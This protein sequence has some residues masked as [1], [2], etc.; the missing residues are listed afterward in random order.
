MAAW[1]LAESEAR[2]A[3]DALVPL[4][5]HDSDR[6]VRKT[7]VWALGELE[8]EKAVPV[9]AEVLADSDP[10]VRETAAWAL[11]Q[12]E[13]RP[14]PAALVKAITDPDPQVRLAAAWSLSQIGDAA[15]VPALVRAFRAE[16]DEKVRRAEIRALGEA[17][18]MP[19]EVVKEM[20]DSKDARTREMGVRSLAGHR[21]PWPWPWPRPRP[22]PAP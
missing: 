9:L 4:M 11:G 14:A 1:A 7:A 18:E 16:K 15:A 10:E 20:L 5:R 17:G 8:V 13:P 21:A 19:D 12:I 22:R 6:R 3:A 2:D